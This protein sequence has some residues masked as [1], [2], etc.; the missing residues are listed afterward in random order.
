MI[1]V[2]LPITL[3]LCIGTGG[4]SEWKEA[5]LGLDG[6]SWYDGTLPGDSERASYARDVAMLDAQSLVLRAEIL[7]QVLRSPRHREVEDVVDAAEQ[8]HAA[9][10]RVDP[11]VPTVRGEVLGR[12]G[13]HLRWTDSI[14]FADSASPLNQGP[15]R[16][17]VAL[18]MLSLTN[19]SVLLDGWLTV[20]SDPF[21]PPAP[22][23]A[24]R[25]P[26][27]AGHR[28]DRVQAKVAEDLRALIETAEIDERFLASLR[29]ELSERMPTKAEHV[30]R[31][32]DMIGR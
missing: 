32:F 12:A 20:G 2:L 13:L 22:D 8:I 3:V 27:M 21:N 11:R 31:A 29:L 7:D 1:K 10:V 25:G 6:E 9:V 15:G 26:R 5:V 30:D 19:E 24:G 23:E 28:L 4:G 18:A 16:V 17:V 14:R